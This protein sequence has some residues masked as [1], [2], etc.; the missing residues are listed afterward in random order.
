MVPA[1]GEHTVIKVGK[2]AVTY[3]KNL[4]NKG[5]CNIWEHGTDQLIVLGRI[6]EVRLHLSTYLDFLLWEANEIMQGKC[7]GK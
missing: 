3:S 4:S 6:G 5:M 1:L 7:G 2:E